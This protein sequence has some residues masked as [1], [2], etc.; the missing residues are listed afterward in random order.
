MSYQFEVHP[1]P[2]FIR[3]EVSGIRKPGEAAE[4]AHAV[5]RE[6]TSV[7]RETGID[8]ILLVVDLSG[9]LSAIDAFEIVT[10]SQDY[11]W[12][13]AFKLAFVDL[14]A[15]SLADSR[16]TET[17]ALNRAYRMQVFDNEDDAREW[18]LNT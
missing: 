4:N 13:H 17:V 10:R 11:G 14:N 16:F 6:I 1:N 3:V 5:G 7:C 8:R 12:S 15:E 18:L 9:R 2:D